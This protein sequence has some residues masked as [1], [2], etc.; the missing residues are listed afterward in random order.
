MFGD[1]LY[2]DAINKPRSDFGSG[3]TSAAGRAEGK[4]LNTSACHVQKGLD[5][6][7]RS[8]ASS[9]IRNH[10][11]NGAGISLDEGAIQL[12]EMDKSDRKCLSLETAVSSNPKTGPVLVITDGKEGLETQNM[13][14]TSSSSSKRA[15]VDKETVG[16][17]IISAGSQEEY[18]R[19]Q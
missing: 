6:D 18:C 9:I 11:P 1:W 2:A 10:P 15:K 12:M 4:G 14:P 3:G 7:Q 19:E 5:E 13:S 16:N 8:T 17:E